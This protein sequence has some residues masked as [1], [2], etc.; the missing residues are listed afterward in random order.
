MLIYFA[1]ALALS[2]AILLV[3][4]A[5][6]RSAI[7]NRINGANGL[8]LLAAF[9]VS[10]LGSLL[11]SLI[12]AWLWG[13]LAGLASLA[14]SGLWHWTMWNLVMRNVQRLVDKTLGK[15]AVP[16]RNGA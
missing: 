10:G 7:K 15:T 8:T 16:N 2:A 1:L 12:A 3:A 11:V 14:I 5:M 13:W 9:I 6:E 4:T